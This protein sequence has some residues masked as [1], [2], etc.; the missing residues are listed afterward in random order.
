[1]L[2]SCEGARGRGRRAPAQPSA[3]AGPSAAQ[4]VLP[5]GDRMWQ[6]PQRARGAAPGVSTAVNTGLQASN[7]FLNSPITVYC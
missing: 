1:M 5:N 7:T 6:P 2:R 3:S 4:P